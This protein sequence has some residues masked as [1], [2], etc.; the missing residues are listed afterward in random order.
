VTI[1]GPNM[2]LHSVVTGIENVTTYG[3]ARNLH[4]GIVHSEVLMDDLFQ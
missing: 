2:E 1:L 3:V 4:S